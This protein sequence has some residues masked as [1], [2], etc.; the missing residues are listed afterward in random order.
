MLGRYVNLNKQ[1]SYRWVW[2]KHILVSMRSAMDYLFINLSNAT[3]LML[4]VNMKLSSPDPPVSSSSLFAAT[5]LWDWT[6]QGKCH[7]LSETTNNECILGVHT[8]RNDSNKKV[9]LN[10]ENNN[11]FWISRHWCTCIQG[12]CI[13]IC[14]HC[15]LL[16]PCFQDKDSA[17]ETRQ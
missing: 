14:V 8:S 1:G 15:T 7:A 12:M 11:M 5:V 10:A 16:A 9:K 4:P 2:S 17:L 3:N 13:F 6:S